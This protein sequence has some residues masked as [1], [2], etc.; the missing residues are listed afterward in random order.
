VSFKNKRYRQLV[1]QMKGVEFNFYQALHFILTHGGSSLEYPTNVPDYWKARIIHHFGI[2]LTNPH[3]PR[4]YVEVFPANSRAS[5]FI[6][7]HKHVIYHRSPMNQG[8]EL[9]LEW[10]DRIKHAQILIDFTTRYK[11]IKTRMMKAK[12]ELNFLFTKDDITYVRDKL[13][14]PPLSKQVLDIINMKACAC[15]SITFSKSQG[16]V[17]FNHSG[18]VKGPGNSIRAA[19]HPNHPP[20]FV[21]VTSERGYHTIDGSTCPQKQTAAHIRINEILNYP[22]SWYLPPCQTVYRSTEFNYLNVNPEVQMLFNYKQFQM[23][24]PINSPQRNRSHADDD[25]EERQGA[26]VGGPRP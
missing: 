7:H 24:V 14:F 18:D 26:P 12:E 17:M 23:S 20:P 10:F 11:D 16:G 2:R 9:S 6:F 3:D 25:S 21:K 22:M 1:K 19:N 4:E 13:D 15:H 8:D 5:N